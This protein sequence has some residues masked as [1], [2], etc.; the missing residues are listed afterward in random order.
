MYILVIDN[1]LLHVRYASFLLTNAGY[2]VVQLYD[3]PNVLPTMAQHRPR[4]VL[5][6][7]SLPSASGFVVCRQ[8]R[9]SYDVAVI[10][11]SAHTSVEARVMGLQAGGDD[12]LLKPF[13]PTELLVRIETVLRRYDRTVIA[14]AGTLKQGHILLDYIQQTV[15]VDNGR[16]IELTPIEFRMLYYL[17]EN[18]GRIL[19]ASQIRDSVWNSSAAP[20]S[21]QVALYIRRLRSKI[22]SDG[23]RPRHILTVRNLGYK[24]EP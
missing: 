12:Y 10:F 22:E 23:T 17:M 16:P 14:T 18:A 9:E 20:E 6:D 7:V 8:I 2:R 19:T 5:L 11:L 4:L 1:D 13:E 15:S 24:F 21:N 3:S